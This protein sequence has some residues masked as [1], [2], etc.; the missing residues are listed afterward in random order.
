MPWQRNGNWEPRFH[1]CLVEMMTGHPD[2]NIQQAI[3][4]QMSSLAV[5][6]GE[7]AVSRQR[8]IT[9]IELTLKPMSMDEFSRREKRDRETV[10]RQDQ[11][12]PWENYLQKVESQQLRGESSRVAGKST[13]SSIREVPKKFTSGSGWCDA[14]EMSKKISLGRDGNAT[15]WLTLILAPFCSS[16]WHPKLSQK[17]PVPHP[18]M[19][20]ILIH[21]LLTQVWQHLST[22]KLR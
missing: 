13:Q 5:Q 17:L 9:C 6:S 4:T 2:G 18:S 19:R 21:S 14:A 8:G 20:A 11:K 12:W 1:A 10:Q 7:N 15:G 3:K 16:L 22:L